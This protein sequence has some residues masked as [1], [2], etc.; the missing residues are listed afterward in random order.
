MTIGKQLLCY[1]IS[2]FLMITVFS[3]CSNKEES[4]NSQDL[5]TKQKV[6]R[7]SKRLYEMDKRI[8]WLEMQV[9]SLKQQLS[10]TK[11]KQP[12]PTENNIK[13]DY[14]IVQ[15]GD[16]LYR[17]AMQFDLSVSE[18]R[19]YNHLSNQDQIYVGQKLIVKE[20]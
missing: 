4:N 7:L 11:E 19:Q 15:P 10:V 3:S 9:D 20:N 18:I 1:L 13:P 12:E 16:T 6:E 8:V 17:I 2:F 5:E 14:Y